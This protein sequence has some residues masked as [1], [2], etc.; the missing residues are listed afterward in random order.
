MWQEYDI[1][2]LTNNMA[3]DSL[4]YLQIKF[5]LAHSLTFTVAAYYKRKP[6]QL[7]VAYF[8]PKERL[9]VGSHE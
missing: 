1:T 9:S 5:K 2:K 8:D 7:E 6:N 4:R 3:W